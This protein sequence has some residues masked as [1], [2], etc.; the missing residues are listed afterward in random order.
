MPVLNPV[1]FQT[2]NQAILQDVSDIS[3]LALPILFGKKI[4][5]Y[6]I[7]FGI[8]PSGAFGSDQLESVF[9]LPSYKLYFDYV[10][11]AG[12]DISGLLINLR[13]S[14]SLIGFP[15]EIYASQGISDYLTSPKYRFRLG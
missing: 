1:T 2:T 9:S 13:Y 5:K 14:N 6:R 7:F 4:S 3:T 12:V 15:V 10:V 8:A 11:G